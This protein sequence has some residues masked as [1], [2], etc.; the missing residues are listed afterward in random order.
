MERLKVCNSAAIAISALSLVLCT[1]TFATATH[2]FS[3]TG[4]TVL[5][6]RRTHQKCN[7]IIMCR[8]IEQQGDYSGE[9]GCQIGSDNG[10]NSSGTEAAESEA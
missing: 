3:V 7:Y 10:P 1:V 4:A 8:L 2:A 6:Q 5:Q 9:F